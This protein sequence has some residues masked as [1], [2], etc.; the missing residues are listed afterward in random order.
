MSLCRV[1][2]EQDLWE[3]DQEQERKE[4]ETILKPNVQVVEPVAARAVCG[5]G[6]EGADEWVAGVLGRMDN[7]DALNAE[8]QPLTSAAPPVLS[9]NAQTVAG[10]W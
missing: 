6:A 3:R 7:V 9:R 8:L 10:P 5:A 1:V 4:Q 2:T